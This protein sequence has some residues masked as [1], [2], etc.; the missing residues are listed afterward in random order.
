[1]TPIRG[2][3]RTGGLGNE[4]NGGIGPARRSRCGARRSRWRCR[5][6]LADT[7]RVLRR[8]PPRRVPRPRMCPSLEQ[9]LQPR[10]HPLCP[11]GPCPWASSANGKPFPST[12]MT[13]LTFFLANLHLL[14]KV[15]WIMIALGALFAYWLGKGRDDLV[16]Q[17]P[18]GQETARRVTGVADTLVG[19][20]LTHLAS[21]SFQQLSPRLHPA[22]LDR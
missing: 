4:H 19:C 6:C 5:V 17:R 18:S 16:P 3:F 7:T 1:M 10:R 22:C 15:T 2:A 12:P 8:G 13:G 21:F 9:A 11:G 14:K 20:V